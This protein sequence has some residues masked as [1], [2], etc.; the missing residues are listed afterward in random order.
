M[1]VIFIRVQR[2][3]VSRWSWFRDLFWL[4]GCEQ[5]VWNECSEPSANVYSTPSSPSEVHACTL[6]KVDYLPV[7]RV[8]L[9][10]IR[11]TNWECHSLDLRS[12]GTGPASSRH[13]RTARPLKLLTISRNPE[14]IFLVLG[15]DGG[16]Q[17]RR[18]VLQGQSQSSEKWKRTCC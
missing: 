10:G 8:V 15:Q 7:S 13:N 11:S 14:E 9:V 5:L 2:K 6:R 18:G 4:S 1:K 12:V 3:Q 16:W 17:S